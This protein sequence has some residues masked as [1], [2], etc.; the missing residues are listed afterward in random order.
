MRIDFYHLEKMSFEEAVP[1]VLEKA[2]ERGNKVLIRLE[3]AAACDSLNQILWTYS[4][5]SFVP[6]GVEKDGFPEWQPIF[7]THKR[8]FN[9]AGAEIL[10]VYNPKDVPD[11]AG[12]SRALIFFNGMDEEALK[13]ARFVWRNL[14]D[15]GTEL[16]YWQKENG[17]WAEKI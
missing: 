11:M 10:V 7:I 1:L 17:R 15:E 5:D 9:P 2:Y 8:D 4:P 14:R 13:D 12:F 3:G 16:H 6:H